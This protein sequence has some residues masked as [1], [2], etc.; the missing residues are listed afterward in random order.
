MERAQGVTGARIARRALH[1]PGCWGYDAPQSGDARV[2]ARARRLAIATARVHVEAGP[3]AA[4]SLLGRERECARI[5][6]L[7]RAAAEGRSG[8]LLIFGERGIG[9]SALLDYAAEQAGA[10]MMSVLSARGVEFESDLRFAGL[11][12]LLRPVQDRVGEIPPL[13]ASALAG[14]LA[15][16]RAVAGDRFRVNAGALSLLTVV[17]EERPLACLVDDAHWLDSGSLE[18]LLFAAR[19]FEAEGVALL[20]AVDPSEGGELAAARLPQLLLR[21]LDPH[22]GAELLQRRSAT[23]VAE[24]VAERAHRQTG[25]NPLAIIELAGL[26]TEGQLAGRQALDDP[27]PAGRTIGQAF[28]R[29]IKGLPHETQRA[30]IVAAAGGRDA[31]AIGSALS[32]LEIDKAALE[33]A[34]SAGLI[35]VAQGK[36][37]FRR[38]LVRSSVYH[39]ARP[40]KRRAAHA[41]LA[42]ALRERP[43]RRAWHLAAAAT[44]PDEAVSDELERAA[45]SAAV[46]RDHG[47]AASAHEQ[48]ARLTM[49]ERKRAQRFLA[50]AQEAKLDG[51]IETAVGLLDRAL[52][53]A[54]DPT[55]RAEVQR[56]RAG[57]ETWRGAPLRAHRLLVEGAARVEALDRRRAA[58]MLAD[59]ALP[60]FLAG[61]VAA[62]IAAARRAEELGEDTGLAKAALGLGLIATGDAQKARPVLIESQ[63]LVMAADPL[64]PQEI[65]HMQGFALMLLGEHAHAR[66]VFERLISAGRAASAPG[67]LPV[68][69]MG[70]AELD[71]LAGRWAEAYA[72][73][74]EAVRLAK[75]TGQALEHCLLTLALVES[76]LGDEGSCREHAS[77]ALERAQAHGHLAVIPWAHAAL[78]SLELSL[79]QA[80]QAVVE[81]ERAFRISG[82]A[83]FSVRLQWGADL[84]EAY[85]N[86]GRRADAE[87]VLKELIALR[88]RAGV[89]IGQ[90]TVARCRALLAADHR[91][92]AAYGAALRLLKDRAMPFE[93]GRTEL[94][95]GERLRRAKRFGE[96]RQH[97]QLA[98]DAFETLGAAMWT[99]RVRAE[100][101][102]M[103]APQRQSAA[104]QTDQL[105]PRE[106]EVALLVARGATN[107]E[108]GASL[109][110]SP[111]TIDFHLCHVYRKLGVRSRVGL[112]QAILGWEEGAGKSSDQGR[113]PTPH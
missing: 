20:L 60:A 54:R 43:D 14:A 113:T 70:L 18:A 55:L 57:A 105:T 92:D 22:A 25:G 4:G 30:L 13:Q 21:G 104:A 110:L 59:A 10:E 36:L 78:G 5:E 94:C 28:I 96:A 33:P 112:A 98:L 53:F 8:T 91:F 6:E 83:A 109:F 7:I 62:G 44:G 58:A 108:A 82:A 31:D 81:L 89:M 34:E 39:G 16:G 1:P 63:P 46:R 52:A 61:D 49:D 56:L 74:A 88:R 97:L 64:G 100:L 107:K 87:R 11:S 38:P 85:R 71:F 90:P 12:A 68:A 99:E 48:A 101:R 95:Y 103:G 73:A 17:A 15:L 9:K 29:T 77:G 37:R 42:E 84:V 106:L 40:A 93:R 47:A 27:L 66:A 80:G 75:Q 79:G 50:G 19:R 51:R 45:L 67:I 72:G 102:A 69:L 76:G 3:T 2:G 32:F 26:L 35:E 111:K 24:Q 65:L 41:A 23:A 86:A